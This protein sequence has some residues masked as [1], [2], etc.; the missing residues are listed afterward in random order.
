MSPSP[1]STYSST[2]TRPPPR[3]IE[4][5]PKGE[6]VLITFPEGAS[7]QVDSRRKRHAI[8]QKNQRDRLKAALEQMAR[9]LH[10]GGVGSGPRRS[11]GTRVELI[12]TAVEYIQRLEKEVKTL[13][14][15][16]N[17]VSRSHEGGECVESD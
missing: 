8:S 17:T 11:S 10:A 2:A 7:G 15:S 9:V 16:V 3:F 1:P 4:L 14:S 5:R 6:G 13:R 12:E